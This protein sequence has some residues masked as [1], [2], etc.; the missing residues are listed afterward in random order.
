MAYSSSAAIKKL[1][2][3]IRNSQPRQTLSPASRRGFLLAQTPYSELGEALRKREWHDTCLPRC[4][5][6]CVLAPLHA[7]GL[8]C[9]ERRSDGGIEGAPRE[10]VNDMVNKQPLIRGHIWLIA[11]GLVNAFAIYVSSAGDLCDLRIYCG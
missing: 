11:L 3:R 2:K 7:V 9:Q 6:T 8:F 10:G 4:Q 5:L 1:W